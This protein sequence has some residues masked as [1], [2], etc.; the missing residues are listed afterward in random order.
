MLGLQVVLS[1]GY[2]F[3]HFLDQQEQSFRDELALYF[4]LSDS[5]EDAF[6]NPVRIL[7]E[8]T[9]IFRNLKL[10]C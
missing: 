1:G 5:N 4:W 8:L 2:H 7:S 6:F 10:C 3:D 9:S